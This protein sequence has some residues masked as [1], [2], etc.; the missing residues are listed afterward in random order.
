M[1]TKYTIHV[2][3]QAWL[4]FDVSDTKNDS[5][6][7]YTNTWQSEIS[8]VTKL[9]EKVFP[10]CID[11]KECKFVNIQYD[12]VSFRSHL[13]NYGKPGIREGQNELI[14]LVRYT[15]EWEKERRGKGEKKVKMGRDTLAGH[16]WPCC[17]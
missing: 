16:T 15:K 17:G 7:Y 9:W 12:T 3:T 1:D 13:F 11:W 5:M 10:T 6:K 14:R 2:L 8:V 4:R